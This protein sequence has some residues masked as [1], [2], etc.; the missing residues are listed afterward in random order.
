MVE[1]GPEKPCVG[2]PILPLG[3]IHFMYDIGDMSTIVPGLYRHY[4]GGIYE[5]VGSVIMSDSHPSYD[6][7]E[8][9]FYKSIKHIHN[10]KHSTDY[11]DGTLFVRLKSEFEGEITYQNKTI[12]RFTYLWPSNARI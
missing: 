7:Q 8:C 11:P 4:R 12:P 6:G 2:S 10:S 3:T 9:I 5:V 1:Q